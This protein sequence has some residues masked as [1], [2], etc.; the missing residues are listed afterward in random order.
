MRTKCLLGGGGVENGVETIQTMFEES[1]QTCNSKNQRITYE[2]FLLLMKGQTKEVLKTGMEAQKKKS[3]FLPYFESPDMDEL[4]DGPLTMDDDDDQ[5]LGLIIDDDIIMNENDQPSDDDSNEIT[6]LT[7]DVRHLMIGETQHE[8]EMNLKK[9]LNDDTKSPLVVNR[10]LYRA[11]RSLR[12]AVVEASK[13]FEEVHQER[14]KAMTKEQEKPR[15]KSS[16]IGRARAS[17]VLR[18]GLC[19][20]EDSEVL[21]RFLNKIKESKKEQEVRIAKAQRLSGRG[22]RNRT[23]VVSDIGAMM[24]SPPKN[25][26][27]PSKSL[28]PIT[29]DDANVSNNGIENSTSNSDQA[30]RH[31]L[32]GPRL[33]A[34]DEHDDLCQ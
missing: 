5:G 9:V 22:R 6:Q 8:H 19:E 12:L 34:I 30:L 27:K 15:A 3:H 18:H 20:E 13:R 33:Q 25:Q 26:D 21:Q 32:S 4:D 29:F 1:L 23:K 2:D 17:L 16:S 31:S 14:M 24:G 7:S 11:H 28:R 10:C